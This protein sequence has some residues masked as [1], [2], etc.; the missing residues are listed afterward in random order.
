MDPRRAPIWSTVCKVLSTDGPVSIGR[1]LANT[2][3]YILDRH[4]QPVPMGVSGELH[5]GER[6]LPAA[7]CAA[8]N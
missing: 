1:P 8:R 3:V 7:T 6:A 4:L 2:Q 5:I